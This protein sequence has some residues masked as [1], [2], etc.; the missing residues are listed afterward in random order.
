MSEGS[1][2][3]NIAW[4]IAIRLVISTILLGSATFMRATETASNASFA[5]DPFFFLIGLTYAR[6]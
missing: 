3:R 2:R 6:R 4:L 1:L 5:G